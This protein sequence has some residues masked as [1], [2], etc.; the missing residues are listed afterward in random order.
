VGQDGAV[1]RGRAV[2]H[3]DRVGF[4]DVDGDDN[5]D[6]DVDRA[7]PASPAAADVTFVRRDGHARS[8]QHARRADRDDQP[9][10]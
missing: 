7:S 6:I 8:A 2:D 1:E 5:I 10:H 9:L 4:C 3:A